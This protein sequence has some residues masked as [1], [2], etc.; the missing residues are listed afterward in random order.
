M[1]SSSG[2][3]TTTAAAVGTSELSRK[4]DDTENLSQSELREVVLTMIAR[5]EQSEQANRSLRA[6]LAEEVA[7]SSGLQEKTVLLEKELANVRHFYDNRIQAIENENKLLKDQLKKYVSAVQ[8]MRPADNT[9]AAAA[10]MPPMPVLN[11]NI[12]RDYSYEAE[13]YEKK[14]IQVRQICFFILKNQTC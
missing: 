4:L 14:L 11:S 5:K 12:Q 13:Q 2:T 1:S 8:L 6:S 10:P 7:K 9:S 3:V